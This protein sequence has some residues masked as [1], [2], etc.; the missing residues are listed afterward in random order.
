M[1]GST[2]ENTFGVQTTKQFDLMKRKIIKI[3]KILIINSQRKID[4]SKGHTIIFGKENTTAS[5]N[6][7]LDSCNVF[8]YLFQSAC[9]LN[10]D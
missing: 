1:F 8:I 7:I 5:M 2:F 4:S 3:Y 10:L 6:K 9:A